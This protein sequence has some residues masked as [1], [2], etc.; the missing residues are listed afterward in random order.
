MRRW[1]RYPVAAIV[2]LHGLIQLLG[3]ASG[4]GSAELPGW[5]APIGAPMGLLWLCGSLLTL[6]TASSM[7]LAVRGWWAVALAAAAVSQVLVISSWADA[8]AGTVGSGVL[9]TAGI[10]GLFSQGPGGLRAEY[11]RR[12]D[13]AIRHAVALEPGARPP[14]TEADLADLPPQVATYLRRTGSVGR[15][16]V[17]SLHATVSGRIRGGPAEPWMS[18]TG[19]QCNS[20]GAHCRRLFFI[21]ATRAGLPVDVLHVFDGTGASMRGRLCSLVPIL[22]A[23]GAELDRSESVTVFNDL[24]V[25]APAAL[26]DAP[27]DWTE[28]DEHRVRGVFHGGLWDVTAD[29]V[30]DDDGD[31]VDF[32]SADRSRFL[33]RHG[34]FVRLPWST[35]VG[36]YREVAGRRVATRGEGRWH[37]ASPEGDFSYLEFRLDDISFEPAGLN[38][39]TLHSAPTGVSTGDAGSARTVRA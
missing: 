3:A 27:V 17:T 5:T 1:V 31:L 10:Y 20:F 6:A 21:D 12:R 23:E 13:A 26:V 8:A 35:P 2:T 16:R 38:G 28:L 32:R 4:L 25:L 24:C 39:R 14:V 34:G 33:G 11:C 37:A 30:F 18:F 22:D 15:P 36:G 29:L 19:E 7:V 9:L